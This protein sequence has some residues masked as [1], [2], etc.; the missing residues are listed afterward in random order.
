[1]ILARR[2]LVIGIP[3]VVGGLF[4][5]ALRAVAIGA[6]LMLLALGLIVVGTKFVTRASAI[7]TEFLKVLIAP[8][9]LFVS[10]A[11]F[12]LFLDNGTARV[13]SL[14]AVCAFLAV[15]F[16]NVFRYYYA[17]RAYQPY[18]L[19]HLSN[20]LNTIIAF[21]AGSSLYALMT[22][23]SVKVWMLSAFAVL[24]FTL[25]VVQSRWTH[26]IETNASLSYIIVFDILILEVFWAIAFLPVNFYVHAFMLALAHYSLWGIFQ[27]KLK[28]TL[29]RSLVFRYSAVSILLLFMVIATSPWT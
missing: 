4:T 7:S 2:M 27:A 22:L 20:S 28:G 1:M 21:L 18:A 17:P 9:L 10:G 13:I 26:G 11:A 14:V 15:F 6:P 24:V 25:L 12:T 23:L 19:E 3:L 8:L 29:D 5:I 16:E